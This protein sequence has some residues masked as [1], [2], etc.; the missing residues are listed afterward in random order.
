MR[1][2]HYLEMLVWNADIV[3]DLCKDQV[4][5]YTMHCQQEKLP[6]N[7]KIVAFPRMPKPHEIVGK[8]KWVEQHWT[9]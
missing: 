9:E 1:F 8:F 4:L 7:C 6:E 3:Q 2:D 5:D